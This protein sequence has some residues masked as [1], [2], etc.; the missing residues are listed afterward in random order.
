[1]NINQKFI[2]Q[3][4]FQ[5]WFWFTTCHFIGVQYTFLSL[6]FLCV[7]KESTKFF[8]Y[9]S[10]FNVLGLLFLG[11]VFF[12][13]IQSELLCDSCMRCLEFALNFNWNRKAVFY[14]AENKFLLQFLLI[15][16]TCL[17]Q[18]IL[19]MEL[20]STNSLV[21]VERTPMAIQDSLPPTL[22]QKKFGT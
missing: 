3:I 4:L 18:F 9:S 15:L 17:L 6:S 12:W 7:L 16:H 2:K 22:R 8:I 20:L 13:Q 1:M 11:F 21:V 5:S 10:L 14:A 19:H